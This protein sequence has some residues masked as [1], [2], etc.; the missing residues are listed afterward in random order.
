MDFR[1]LAFYMTMEETPEIKH[2]ETWQD[3]NGKDRLYRIYNL[4]TEK[5]I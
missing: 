4:S 3:L 1:D 2:A 5:S